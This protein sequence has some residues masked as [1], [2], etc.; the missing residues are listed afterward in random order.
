MLLPC[1]ILKLLQGLP[2][3]V[4]AKTLRCG[5]FDP[6]LKPSAQTDVEN[7]TQAKEG[8]LTRNK[9]SGKTK[10]KTGKGQEEGLL[11]V[12]SCRDVR[13]GSIAMHK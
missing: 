12:V 8:Y 9:F 10:G 3:H 4:Q 11:E 1:I 6:L 2:F 13:G 5:I 7:E